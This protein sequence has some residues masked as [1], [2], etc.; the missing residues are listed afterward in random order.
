MIRGD[1]VRF[2][3]ALGSREGDDRLTEVLAAVGGGY[4]TSTYLDDGVE[5]KYLVSKEHG[6]DFLLE[7]GVLRS[8]FF[9]ARSTAVQAAYDGWDG[10]IDGIRPD[11]SPESLVEVLGAP[12]MATE[13]FAIYPASPGFVRLVFSDGGLKM[14]VA[15]QVDPFDAAPL[16]ETGDAVVVN[17]SGVDEAST[18]DGEL[19]IFMAAVGSAIYSPE[20]R[21]ALVLAGPALE[22]HQDERADATWLY[23]EFP[24]AGVTLQFKN[25]IMIGA[26]I[27]LDGPN[28]YPTPDLLI[29][30][31]PLPCAREALGNRLGKEQVSSETQAFYYVR[32]KY[33]A[34]DFEGGIT[35]AVSVI[36]PDAEA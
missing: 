21:A 14:V 26:L 36:E 9:H 3:D 17:L 25:D 24:K 22:T 27:L 5:S 28:A 12:K 10:L 19:A 2:L 4:E 34:F 7:D 31:L 13:A 15:Q 18:I 35:T 6:V 30:G 32:D 23:Q 8:V 16:P 11:S 29:T 1:I 20:H 33:L